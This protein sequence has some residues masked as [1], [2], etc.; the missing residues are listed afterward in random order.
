VGRRSVLVGAASSGARASFATGVIA[1]AAAA[2]PAEDARAEVPRVLAEAFKYYGDGLQLAGDELVFDVR[3]WIVNKDWDQLRSMLK[4]DSYGNSKLWVTL[5]NPIDRLVIGNEDFLEGTDT[6]S[7]KLARTLRV[8]NATAWGDESVRQER[9]LSQW[10]DMAAIVSKVMT[11]CNKLFLEEQSEFA[12]RQP[13]VLPVADP[14]SYNRS[15][16][17]YDSRCKGVM[18]SGICGP[19]VPLPRLP[20]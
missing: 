4:A 3:P 10:D 13:Y 12:S 18:T 6:L 5:V 20:R 19:G 8:A 17:A 16:K 14:A 1:G 2:L 11:E 7:L 9:L 15:F